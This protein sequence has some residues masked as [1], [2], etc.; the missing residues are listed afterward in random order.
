MAK[1]KSEE[2]VNETTG[3]IIQNMLD[4]NEL[5]KDSLE[6]IVKSNWETTIAFI[7]CTKPEGMFF[8]ELRAKSGLTARTVS[9]LLKELEA[10]GLI[11]RIIIDSHPIRASYAITETGRRL[12]NSGCPIINLWKQ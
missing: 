6:S 1:L 5:R 10:H 4:I 11:K 7:L 3:C 2:K 12:V 9:R 8:N